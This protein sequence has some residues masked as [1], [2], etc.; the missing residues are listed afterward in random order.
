[1]FG[2]NSFILSTAALLLLVG[3][4]NHGGGP[5]NPNEI[6][7]PEEATVEVSPS[8]PTAAQNT[9][10][11][12]K[13]VQKQGNTAVE[14]TE[15]ASWT[16][17]DES[18]ASVSNESG[19]RGTVRTY[20]PG[21][22]TISATAPGGTVGSTTLTVVHRD[23]I[24]IEITPPTPSISVGTSVQLISTGIYQDQTSQELTP[25]AAWTVDDAEIATVE[26]GRV[27]GKK[28]GSATITASHEGVSAAVVVKVTS[29]PLVGIQVTP[30]DPS[31]AEGF[32]IRFIA[33]GLF[34]DGHS[35]DLPDQVQWSSSDAAVVSI[36]AEG[37]ARA[38]SVGTA[39]ISASF[40]G[41]TGSSSM[42]VTGKILRSIEVAGVSPIPRG[43]TSQ[44]TARGT[45][46]NGTVD[47]ISADVAWFTGDPDIAT[48][49]NAGTRGQVKGV[50]KG[51][52][53]IWAGLGSV[54][55]DHVVITIGD[56]KLTGVLLQPSGAVTIAKGL[57]R[58]LIATGVY[59]DGSQRDITAEALYTSSNQTVAA[60]SNA[61]AKGI[62]TALREGTAEI[63]AALE[64][65]V[66]E[67]VT[68][69]VT[70]A[71]L[72]GIDVDPP[73]A[74]IDVGSEQPFEARGLFT[75]GSRETVTSSG[76]WQSSDP[77]V[78]EVSNAA[79]SQGRAK[80]RTAGSVTI[81]ASLD[82]MSGAATLKVIGVES[83]AIQPGS[84]T[85]NEGDTT[86]LNAV[87]TRTDGSKVQV[88]GA[89]WTSDSPA[90][91]SVAGG[92]VRAVSAGSATI[93]A[94]YQNKSASA[95][96]AVEVK[97]EPRYVGTT[98][99]GLVFEL[100]R[101]ADGDI[102]QI[103]YKMHYVGPFCGGNLESTTTFN[104]PLAVAGNHFFYSAPWSDDG[105]VELTGDF[106][107]STVTGSLTYASRNCGGKNR[108]SFTATRQ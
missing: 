5:D 105:M 72:T 98:S 32:S 107:G 73:A 62:V 80:A 90:V 43:T 36:D 47:D 71:E 96:V 8:T 16:S 103:H 104:T 24:R 65:I 106:S 44:Y 13:A 37:L 25:V 66:S 4:C 9:V 64:G 10:L 22:A 33:K 57:T 75:D 79:G 83:L 82:G 61:G 108:I 84:V 53:E 102:H 81:S 69:I 63:T 14:V 48:V 17:S 41:L 49:S 101:S 40:Q 11:R 70:S 38:V 26:A 93:R 35:Q 68:V 94:S 19:S 34:D 39:I 30:V 31:V 76:T 46:S 45:Y 67:P 7:S 86:Q 6:P 56:A 23:L 95:T 91:A 55:S 42:E 15:T 99:Q 85:V 97:S 20:N 51:T 92:L 1:M 87:A 2:K 88:T 27:T 59:T 3:G 89:T 18:T 29:A 21:T 28:E 78:A 12:F 77:S 100:T 74:V 50:S 60:V 58:A 52:T 54:L